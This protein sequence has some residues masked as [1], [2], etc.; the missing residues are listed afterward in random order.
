MVD[1][2]NRPWS[3]WVGQKVS[4]R[5]KSTYGTDNEKKY[6]GHILAVYPNYLLIDVGGKYRVTESYGDWLCGLA[7]ITA[8]NR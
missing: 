3:F 1:I 5:S 7:K 8:T 2:S 4:V 6:D